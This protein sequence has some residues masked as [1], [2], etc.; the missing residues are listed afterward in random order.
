MS[1]TKIDVEALKQVA[2]SLGLFKDFEN[3]DVLYVSNWGACVYAEPLAVE[4]VVGDL[5]PN[6]P[7]VLIQK[8][9]N[10]PWYQVLSHLGLGWVNEDVLQSKW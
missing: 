9:E 3:G 5:E 6:E 1:D 2:T 7:V 4:S 10:R 8:L